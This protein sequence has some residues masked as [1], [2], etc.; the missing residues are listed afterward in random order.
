MKI[1]FVTARV[2]HSSVAGGHALV[3][4][5]IKRL[6][7][8]GHQIGLIS[9]RRPT[10]DKL[11]DDDLYSILHEYEEVPAPRRPG[12]IQRPALLLGSRIPPYFWDYRSEQMMR[13]VGDLVHASRYD[14]AVAEFSAMGQYLYQNRYLPAV[15]KIISCHFSVAS[16]YKSVIKTKGLSAQGL[17]SR[18]SVNKLLT[19]ESGMYRGVDRVIVL[20][21]H[22][23]YML[24]NADPT[25]R[26][27]VI[28]TGVDAD[29]FRPDDKSNKEHAVVF[30]GQYEVD[31][32]FDAVKWFVNTTWPLLKARHPELKF[33]IVGPGARNALEQIAR[34]DP[35]IIITGG[36][37]DVRPYL[38]R[39]KIYVCPVRL[40]S[41]LRFKLFEAMASGI[42][43]VTTSLGA[44]GIPLHNGDN[45]FIGDKPDIMAQCMGL[46]LEDESLRQ[47]MARRARVLMEERFSW[48][49]GID[50]L[51][52]VMQDTF[53]PHSAPGVG[54]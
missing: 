37:E 23:R 40:G 50:L 10:D 9:L 17:R 30:T 6:T 7:A 3:Y 2:P 43:V 47:S 41:G 53:G 25:L 16:A 26:I 38:H 54:S 48:E 22:E 19:Y 33:Y 18:L 32:N 20:T 27:N 12:F 36:V 52:K 5:R 44:E 46:L 14:I 51:E 1:L 29:Y 8:R 49:R 24:L 15:R 42:P 13:R 34:K 39:A 4:Q 45:C 11:P 21:A 28:P 35:S 31:S